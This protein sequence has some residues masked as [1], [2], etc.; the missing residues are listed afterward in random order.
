[1][2]LRIVDSSCGYILVALCTF[3]SNNSCI[4]GCERPH[5]IRDVAVW[6]Y[7][8]LHLLLAVQRYLIGVRVQ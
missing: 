4:G 8:D 1:M 5:S 3:G 7:S 6:D 2:F